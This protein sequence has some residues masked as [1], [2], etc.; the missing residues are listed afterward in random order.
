MGTEGW[1]LCLHLLNRIGANS[2]D[3]GRNVLLLDSQGFYHSGTDKLI[4]SSVRGN[5][6]GLNL[7][8]AFADGD[9]AQCQILR[10]SFSEA[11]GSISLAKTTYGNTKSWV[12]SGLTACIYGSLLV[13]PF[14]VDF[15]AA[16]DAF[17]G[18]VNF[19]SSCRSEED[20][21]GGFI[22]TAI[23]GNALTAS[24][25]LKTEAQTI[26]IQAQG[27]YFP[28]KRTLLLAKPSAQ[29]SSLGLVCQWAEGNTDAPSCQVL[30]DHFS[31]DC[32]NAALTRDRA[33]KQ[34]FI[35]GNLVFL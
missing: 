7:V 27:V 15:L 1:S 4:L 16:G 25:I 35:S 5:A 34:Y 24:V 23:S 31:K 20:V 28:Q 8:C 12:P 33:R 18:S 10:D 6:R 22:I 30:G 19:E 32:G 21:S 29:G 2:S 11:C 3:S 13:A 17:S 26:S 9:S 14:A